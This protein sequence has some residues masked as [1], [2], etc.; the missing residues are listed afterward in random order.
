MRFSIDKTYIL[1][2]SGHGWNFSGGWKT[3][4]NSIPDHIIFYKDK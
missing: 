1:L 3:I 2:V 4:K